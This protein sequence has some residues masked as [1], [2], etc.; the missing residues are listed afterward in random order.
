M[1]V[2]KLTH[3]RNMVARRAHTALRKA[4]TK[5]EAARLLWARSRHDTDF[6]DCLVR[7]ACADAV[8]LGI[9]EKGAR[10]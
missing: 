3:A 9:T 5:Q 2:A 4:A 8:K 7:V 1:T 6:R 10:S